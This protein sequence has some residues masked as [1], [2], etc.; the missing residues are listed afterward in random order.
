[1]R[2]LFSIS[3]IFAYLLNTLLLNPVAL[4]QSTTP[5]PIQRPS[6]S[7]TQSVET[8]KLNP[9][10]NEENGTQAYDACLRELAELGVEFVKMEPFENENGCGIVDP[11]KIMS[12]PGRNS[13]IVLGAQPQLSCSFALRFSSWLSDVSAPITESL[14]RS[15]LFSVATGPGFV[16]RHRNNDNSRKI[17]EHA[18]GNAID[19]NSFGF[20]NGEK[21]TVSDVLNGSSSEKRTLSAL[22]TA[23]CGFFTTVLG[24]GSNEAHNSHFHLDHGKHGRTWNYRICE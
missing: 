11:V 14:T 7:S 15:P 23:S 19:I 6:N 5:I 2:Y 4:A 22:R 10:K 13:D 16:C 17:S 1:M 20:A 24:P 3:A 8:Q 21:L 18:F 12:V 9:V